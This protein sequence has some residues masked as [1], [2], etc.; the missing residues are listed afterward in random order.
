MKKIDLDKETVQL[1]V[2]EVKQFFV[3]Q[4]EEELSDFQARIFVEFL[5]DRPGLHIYN[6]AIED[7]H[8]YMRDRVEDMYG[9]QKRHR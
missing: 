9:L 2:E 7:A 3:E 8:R 6:R 4:R 5:L 1:M